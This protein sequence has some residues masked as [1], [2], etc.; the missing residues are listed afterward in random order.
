[1]IMNLV[2]AKD[3][4]LRNKA[5]KVKKIDKK[6]KK[7]I[8]DM[9]ET[10]DAQSDPEGVGLAA[11]QVGKSLQ[12]FIAKY[13]DL[14]KVVINPEIVKIKK[15]TK[16][17]KEKKP[18]IMEGCLS[19][20]HYYGPLIRSKSVTIKYMDENGKINQEK[21]EGFPAQIV[22]HEI[23]HLQGTLFV[24]R[25]LEQERPLY[26]FSEGEWAEVEL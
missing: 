8:E 24:D 16:K 4:V 12:I 9:K 5:K 17:E 14:T 23:D 21:F 11:P 25:L 13:D 1:M 10:L 3:P 7:L 19:L 2:D 22:L 18:K 26:E 6:V 15:L 20:P